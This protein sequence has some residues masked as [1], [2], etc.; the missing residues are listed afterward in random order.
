MSSF[1]INSITQS[2]HRR[3]PSP[4]ALPRTRAPIPCNMM[5]WRDYWL[6]QQDKINFCH[7]CS[8]GKS[9]FGSYR[10]SM[11]SQDHPFVHQNYIAKNNQLMEG[12]FHSSSEAKRHFKSKF[13]RYIER[14]FGE[15]SKVILNIDS[16]WN[17]ALIRTKRNEILIK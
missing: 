2:S 7:L 11:R 14:G 13:G 12:D 3:S 6:P 10:I 15:K 17:C 5:A 9:T 16:K 1:L 4:V 8:P